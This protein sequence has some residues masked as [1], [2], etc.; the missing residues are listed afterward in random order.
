MAKMM[1]EGEG[2]DPDERTRLAQELE[3]RVQL[4]R[5]RARIFTSLTIAFVCTVVLASV[6]FGFVVLHNSSQ[7]EATNAEQFKLNEQSIQRLT[8]ALNEAKAALQI[9]TAAD[10]ETTTCSK[11]YDTAVSSSLSS[12]L[13]ALG[14]IAIAGFSTPPAPAPDRQ[15][16]INAA[17]TTLDNALTAYTA[18]IDARSAW[19]EMGT[20]LPCPLESSS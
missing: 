7:R 2:T 1:I 20:P 15:T 10:E 4:Y 14:D 12:F 8:D 13:S 16:A 19:Q 18:A 17:V 9:A 5:S 6:I 11:R 3:L